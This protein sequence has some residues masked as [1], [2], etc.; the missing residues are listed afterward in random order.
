MNS[1]QLNIKAGFHELLPNSYMHIYN[2]AK[3]F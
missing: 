3:L 2:D 1:P